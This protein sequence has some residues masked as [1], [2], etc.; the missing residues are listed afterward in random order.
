ML[1]R[2][3][4]AFSLLFHYMSLDSSIATYSGGSSGK[5][6]DGDLQVMQ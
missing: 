3:G 2:L 6:S 5:L 4:V 1:H